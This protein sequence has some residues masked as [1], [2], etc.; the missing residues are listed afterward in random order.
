MTIR[1]EV[2]VAQME[3][4]ETSLALLLIVNCPVAHHMKC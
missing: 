3:F 4:Y 1:N 2:V